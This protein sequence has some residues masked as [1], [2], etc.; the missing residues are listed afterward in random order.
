M[1]QVNLAELVLIISVRKL[2]LTANEV[3]SISKLNEAELYDPT[4]LKLLTKLNVSFEKYEPDK[5]VMTYLHQQS[6]TLNFELDF[7]NPKEHVKERVSRSMEKQSRLHESSTKKRKREDRSKRLSENKRKSPNNKNT[8][9]ATTVP[10]K[11]QCKRPDCIARGTNTNHASDQCRF[12]NKVS[13]GKTV[14][15]HWLSSSKKDQKDQSECFIERWCTSRTTTI[16]TEW[17]KNIIPSVRRYT[18]VL[19]LQRQRAHSYHL[20]TKAG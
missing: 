15:W 20:P 8:G 12:K 6:R 5:A 2:H 3:T 4:L 1:K 17:C 18:H 19:H 14:P 11:L 16:S 10:Y 9:T 7:R 13:N